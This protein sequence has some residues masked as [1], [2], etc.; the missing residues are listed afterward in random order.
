MK[1]IKSLIGKGLLAGLFSAVALFGFTNSAQATQIDYNTPGNLPSIA[2]PVFNTYNNVPN[3]INNEADFV[4]IRPST[5]D[6]T[7]NGTNGAKNMLY[8]NKLAVPCAVGAKYDVRTYIHNGADDDLN[9]NG[10]GSA[11]AHGVRLAMSAPLGQSGTTF[12]FASTISASNAA[13]VSDDATLLCDN[14]VQLKLIPQTVKVYSKVLGY[15]TLPNSAVNGTTTI[16]TNVLGSGDVWACW[17]SVMI[18]V[19]SVEVVEAPQP[20]KKCDSLTAVAIADRK[21]RF[22]VNATAQNG[23]T[24]SE[25]QFNFGDGKTATSATNTIEHDYTAEGNYTITASVKFMVNGQSFVV[26]GDNCVKQVTI[27]KEPETP[28]YT[29]DN[30]TLTLIR[31]RSYKY[32]IKATAKGGAT[33]KGYE[34]NFGDN[35]EV[36]KSDKNTV[37]H[38]YAKDGTYTSTATVVF[39]VDGQEKRVSGD[40]CKKTVSFEHNKPMCDVP[41]KGHLP[42][43]SPDCKVL[44]VTTTLPKTGAGSIFGLMSVVTVAGSFLHRR[45]TLRRNS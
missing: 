5:G 9:N 16:G 11:V 20:V 2:N 6:P 23:A 41:G 31:D 19:Y 18:V 39:M 36:V 25:Y 35:T 28:V 12:K 15:N 27:E 22:T 17:N 13:S 10:A 1:S 33:I 4:R 45:M 32:E 44:G 34:Y 21:Y 30:F 3:G 42:K 7:D 24:I 40:N 29:C 26:T 43:D 38:T 14:S 8:T 37:E